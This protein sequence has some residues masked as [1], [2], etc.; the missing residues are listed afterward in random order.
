MLRRPLVSQL[1]FTRQL[2]HI[3][4]SDVLSFDCAKRLRLSLAVGISI[5]GTSCQL[6][7]SSALNA[8]RPS[9]TCLYPACGKGPV[10]C[11]TPVIF[12]ECRQSWGIF[13][14]RVLAVQSALKEAHL[15]GRISLAAFHS[16]ILDEYRMPRLG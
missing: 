10:T 5:R 12:V 14:W 6:Q 2:P 9:Q 4:A 15:C 7:G 8:L 11:R 3:S 1:I 16:L 13:E